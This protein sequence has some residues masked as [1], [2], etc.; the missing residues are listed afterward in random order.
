M[1]LEVTL[2]LI[3]LVAGIAFTWLATRF[4]TLENAIVLSIEDI[5]VLMTL[6]ENLD[7]IESPEQYVARLLKMTPEEARAEIEKGRLLELIGQ[8]ASCI[9]ASLRLTMPETYRRIAST[10]EQSR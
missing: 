6:L 7:K 3:L 10:L 9:K 5:L 1:L 8:K 4:R 2:F